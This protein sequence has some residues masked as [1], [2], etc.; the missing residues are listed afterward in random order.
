MPETVPIQY[1]DLFEFLEDYRANLS[2]LQY[3]VPLAGTKVGDDVTVAVTVPVLG[4][5]VMVPGRVMAPMKDQ[6]G[7]QLDPD[8]ADGLPRL[9]GFYRFVGSLVE[10]MLVSGRFKVTGQWA[11][12]ATPQIAAPSA[13]PAPAGGARPEAA[14]AELSAADSQGTVTLEGLTDLFMRLYQERVTGVLRI[15]GGV[16]VRRAY[17][18]SG[19]IVAWEAEPVLEQ[20][21]LGVLLV[22]AG[23]LQEDQLKKTL[24]MMNDTG[25]KQGECLIEMGV[26]TFPQIVMALMTQVEIVTRNV[27]GDVGGT[28]SFHPTPNLGRDFITPPM[29]SPGFLFKF[30]KKYFATIPQEQVEALETP[31]RD[32]YTKLQ[33]ANW[34][35]FRL[36]KSERGLIDIL[37]KRSYR[38]REVFRVSNVGRNLTSQILLTLVEMK[39]LT[40]VDVEDLDQLA[41]RW[42][43]TLDRKLMLQRDQNP[44]ELLE[45][46]WTSRT[47]QVEEA[48]QRLIAEYEGYGRGK[49]LPDDVETMRKQIL[50]NVEEAYLATKTKDARVET[51]KKHYEPQQHEFSADLLFKQ[52]EMLMVRHLWDEVIE[53]FERAIELQPGVAKYRQFLKQAQ[54]KKRSSGG[55]GGGE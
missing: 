18:K 44:F 41:S 36:S 25:M 48:Y 40:F 6:A 55:G 35:D 32:R 33:E 8:A 4:D 2:Q 9:E 17:F 34:D 38:Y 16:A 47:P 42:R 43:K 52:G 3:T 53:G 29:K 12:G 26:F 7:L 45:V 19:G 1:S 49:V 46:H 21:C 51:R 31:R 22:R 10:A 14:P 20:E 27:F 13:T 5:T 39:S 28:W 11:E 24:T 50:A 54:Q 30:Y 15:A 37:S 23:R